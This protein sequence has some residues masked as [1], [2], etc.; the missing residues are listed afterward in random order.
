M[1]LHFD[2]DPHSSPRRPGPEGFRPAPFDA[3]DPR[4]SAYLLGELSPAERLEIEAI[5][6]EDL[7][8]RREFEGLADVADLVRLALELAP[9][10]AAGSATTAKASLESLP[11][12]T[13]VSH[14]AAEK[15]LP[16]LLSSKLLSAS[17]RPRKRIDARLSFAAVVATMGLCLALIVQ[18]QGLSPARPATDP[19]VARSTGL[20]P[21][22]DLLDR[23][24]QIVNTFTLA[25]EDNTTRFRYTPSIAL[26]YRAEPTAPRWYREEAVS[27]R[28][29]GLSRERFLRQRGA[30]AHDFATTNFFHDESINAPQ[31]PQ[32]AGA[33]NA[34][35][36][37]PVETLA[38]V[39]PGQTQDRPAANPQ[40]RE[41]R[42]VSRFQIPA[43][44]PVAAIPVQATRQT[45]VDVE[46]SLARG[47]WPA[48]ESIR[49]EEMVNAFEY[50]DPLPP[51]DEV[52]QLR[53]EA[54]DCPWNERHR[55][56]RVGVRAEPMNLQQRPTSR[57]V[58]MVN[59][60]RPETLS[61]FG[62]SLAEASQLFT[63]LDRVTVVDA[64]GQV[65]VP[66]VAGDQVDR[67]IRDLT[68]EGKNRLG[69]E[70]KPV[71]EPQRALQNAYSVANQHFI[72]GANNR[73]VMVFDAPVVT[74][75]GTEAKL[76]ELV[77][78]NA[79][80]G[81][82]LSAV[83]LNANF[84]NTSLYQLVR[85]GNG[86][87]NTVSTSQEMSGAVV[88][89]LAGGPMVVATEAQFE[90]EFNPVRV[91]AY[92]LLG[93]EHWNQETPDPELLA[94]QKQLHAGDRLCAVVEVRLNPDTNSTLAMGSLRYRQQNDTAFVTMRDNEA[95][96][97]PVDFDKEWLTVR[98]TYTPTGS[99]L[100]AIREVPFD[101]DADTGSQE[102]RWAA[103]V[104][105]FG[106]L[107]KEPDRLTANTLEGIRQR[108]R[109]AVGPDARGD[110]GQFLTL[111]ERAE[112]L[113]KRTPQVRSAPEALPS[114]EA[115]LRA[116][117]DGRY[118]DLLDKIAVPDDQSRYG[119]FHELGY[120]GGRTYRG[121]ADLPAGY[122][123]YVYPHW[124][125]WG[126]NEQ[127]A[128]MAAP[129]P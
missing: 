68:T 37:P 77:R 53:V 63:P 31:T 86:S 69:T 50:D 27:N 79:D 73:V 33:E 126:A 2:P 93:Y 101:G 96:T 8:A 19:V 20:V 48:P 54:G 61:Q 9:Q 72:A 109:Q 91:E 129:P 119:V 59:T 75:A 110:R 12:T 56:V 117:C 82:N 124:Y 102:V 97:V 67:T 107:L 78:G 99:S 43:T 51:G 1:T 3:D 22:T 17:T 108:A 62:E 127:Q 83:D 70:A 55:L 38:V 10:T 15:A 13:E 106:Q 85:T 60:T 94:G 49:L 4:W 118:R 40:P 29:D 23:A 95:P 74:E 26:A 80:S 112:D 121:H 105:D 98:L 39:T 44:A 58:F 25:A 125:I 90:I 6:E 45:M 81:V 11:Q 32:P 42:L 16:L 52:V 76:A 113:V 57:L 71:Q 122:W 47:E 46:Q 103:S 128:L 88:S 7:T 120:Q 123:V 18:S 87:V 84:G 115:R 28:L 24:G 100:P 92:R 21:T 89:E 104:V 114:R 14:A 64:N 30:M 116:S 65:A 35:A 34:P 36:P 111:L 5:L 66:T 41:V